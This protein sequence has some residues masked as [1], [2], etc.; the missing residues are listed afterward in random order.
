MVTWP[1]CYLLTFSERSTV[2]AKAV[3]RVSIDAMLKAVR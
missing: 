2:A 1:W 3:V